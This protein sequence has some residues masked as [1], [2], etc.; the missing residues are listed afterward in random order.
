VSVLLCFSVDRYAIHIRAAALRRYLFSSSVALFSLLLTSFPGFCPLADCVR[1]VPF[2][3]SHEITDAE[4]DL[5]DNPIEPMK[6]PNMV[7]N[8]EAYVQTRIWCALLARF[9]IVLTVLF[10]FPQAIRRRAIPGAD[11]VRAQRLAA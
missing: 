9:A 8:G 1:L 3:N 2:N 4:L 11:R 10:L 7:R 5:F 6:V